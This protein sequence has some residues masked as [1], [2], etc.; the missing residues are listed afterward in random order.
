M[1][2]QT[3]K[4]EVV[5]VKGQFVKAANKAAHGEKRNRE[6]KIVNTRS[7]EKKE[8]VLSRRRTALLR[9]GSARYWYRAGKKGTTTCQTQGRRVKGDAQ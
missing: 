8:G 3:R 1:K 4:R 5:A 7:R 6:E 9:K 2:E